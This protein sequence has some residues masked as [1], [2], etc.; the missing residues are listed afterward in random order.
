MDCV[1]SAKIQFLAFRLAWPGFPLAGATEQPAL[2]AAHQ[3]VVLQLN[4]GTATSE[5]EQPALVVAH[6]LMEKDMI[7]GTAQ[8]VEIRIREDGSVVWINVDGVCAF[9][10]CQIKNLTLNDDRIWPHH[11]V[12]NPK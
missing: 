12:K 8:E 3:F 6:P 2:V 9:R 7:A 10:I 11:P 5:T 1:N 4:S